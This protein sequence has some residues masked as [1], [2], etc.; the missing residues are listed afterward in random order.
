MATLIDTYQHHTITSDGIVTNTKTKHIKSQWVGTN[1]YLHVDIQENGKAT[2]HALHRLLALQFIPNPENKRT[3]NHIDGNKLNN[4]LSNLEWATASENSQHAY[5]TG[6]Q[7]YRRNYTLAEYEEFLNTVMS[8]TSLTALATSINQSLTQL[9][10]HVKEAA[11]R[12][13]KLDD[14]L[15]ELK[16]QKSLQQRSADRPTQAVNMI[17]IPSQT[18]LQTFNSMSDATRYLN[19]VSSGPISNVLAGRQKSAYGYFWSRA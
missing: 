18:I 16:R 14:Y 19:K 12:L 5:D 9:S 10:I 8:G 4:S 15:T 17:D 1:G 7:P 2:K 13:N 3:V 11:I 6:L